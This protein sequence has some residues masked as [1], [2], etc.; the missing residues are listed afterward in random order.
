MPRQARTFAAFVA[1]AATFTE[2]LGVAGVNYSEE[3]GWEGKCNCDATLN[4][5]G[6]TL[7]REDLGEMPEE[8][9]Q[10]TVAIDIR[11]KLSFEEYVREYFA[12]GKPVIV[13]DATEDWPLFSIAGQ[14]NPHTPEGDARF[15]RWIVEQFGDEVHM[16]HQSEVQDDG[17]FLH[18]DVEVGG[19]PYCD[20]AL[21]QGRQLGLAEGVPD[22]SG[23]YEQM[24]E[25]AP[26]FEP[27]MGLWSWHYFLPFTGV[28][29]AKTSDGS[30]YVGG[31]PR[32]DRGK[33]L[34]PRHQDWG[35]C[36]VGVQAQVRGKKRWRI[37]SPFTETQLK[38]PPFAGI[39]GDVNV[40]YEGEI[41]PGEVLVW[42]VQM[43]HS[44]TGDDFSFAFQQHFN[45]PLVAKVYAS[46]NRKN[47]FTHYDYDASGEAQ[48][49]Q[50]P[51]TMFYQKMLAHFACNEQLSGWYCE[52]SDCLSEWSLSG[53]S[54]SNAGYEMMRGVAGGVKQ[55]LSS[56][57]GS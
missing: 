48:A 28:S 6:Y 33:L 10:R 47:T 34:F 5:S 32:V 43:F 44:T 40:V 49:A 11:S 56:G 22:F 27:F 46:R 41:H 42:P 9:G 3:N 55:I 54:L 19:K 23:L 31:P 26:T 45:I 20:K 7:S 4:A 18:K 35:S 25:S 29:G 37:Q 1:T 50:L 15:K 39:L 17:T 36:L 24:K 57:D 38:A 2:W 12:F 21:K 53:R 8:A 51:I 14:G 30:A 13:T 52:N 16:E